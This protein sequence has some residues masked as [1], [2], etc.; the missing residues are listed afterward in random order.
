VV[1]DDDD[2]DHRAQILST[3][4]GVVVTNRLLSLRKLHLIETKRADRKR[5]G[6]LPVVMASRPHADRDPRRGGGGKPYMTG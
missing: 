3:V 5:W 1:I 2:A 6:Q 4:I